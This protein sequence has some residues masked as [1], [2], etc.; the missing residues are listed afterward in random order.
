MSDC[1]RNKGSRVCEVALI[2]CGTHQVSQSHTLLFHISRAWE[3]LVSIVSSW[4]YKL[5]I[6]AVSSIFTDLSSYNVQYC[7]KHPTA[8]KERSPPNTQLKIPTS[9]LN[10]V[11]MCLIIDAVSEY[12]KVRQILLQTNLSYHF[13][14]IQ[15]IVMKGVPWHLLFVIS[16]CYMHAS[17][18]I[19]G[20]IK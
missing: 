9:I 5:S 6:P 4:N 7:L 18:R 20:R 12:E 13:F 17:A 2:T 10:T 1:R 16:A 19:N 14:N 8:L 11:K 15:E 3:I